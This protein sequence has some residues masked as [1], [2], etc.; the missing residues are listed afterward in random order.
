MKDESVEKQSLPDLLRKQE[1][2]TTV[3]HPV[4]YR[5]N[6][7]AD[8]NKLETL[9]QSSP[10]VTIH[11]ELISQLQELI[12]TKN[13]KVRL[14]TTELDNGVVAHLGMV[15]P[16]EYG[17][18]VYY[19]WSHKLIHLL[20][21]EEF[22]EVRT[23]RNQYK[24]TVAERDQLGKLKIG[25]VGLSV[26][27]TIAIT[28][29]MERGF[30]EI[31]LADFDLLELTNLNRIQAGVYQL[32]LSK[33]I[34]AAREI[35]EIDPFLKCVCFTEGLTEENMARFFQEGGKLN[36]LVEECDGLD[37]KI[38]CR[39]MA[40]ALQI[41]VV[42][43]LND[44]GML[45]VERFDLEPERALLHG[46][47]DH[48]DV[49]RIKDLTNEQ[50]IPYLLPMIGTETISSKLKASMIEVGQSISSWPQLASS[51]VLGGA[52]T[53]DVC[54]R[55][56]L[57]QYHE[58]GRYFVDF[59][60]LVGDKNNASLQN[61]IPADTE[62]ELTELEMQ[63]MIDCS[64]V[65]PD[66][67]QL[68]LT[69]EQI[70]DLVSAAIAAPSG[71]NAQPWKWFVSGNN[72][73]LFHDRIRSVSLLD[74]ADTASHIGLG[75]ATENLILKAH[76]M[77]LE[78]FLKHFLPGKDKLVAMFRFYSKDKTPQDLPVEPHAVDDLASVI[79]LRST[80]RKIGTRKPIDEQ[81]LKE[82]RDA[83]RTIPGAGL[84]FLQKPDDLE[85]CGEIIASV[86]R[87]RLL[88]TVGH[89]NFVNEI[90]WTREEAERT[91]D[92]VDLETVDLTPSEHIGFLMARHNDVIKHL[93]NWKGGRAFENLA[94][95]S[96][97]AA[98]CL[99]LVTMPSYGPE[100]FFQGGRAV[101]RAW[102][103]ANKR[104]ISF[105]P[106]SPCTFFFSRLIQ[107]KGAGL[108]PETQ[109]EL[110]K[111]RTSFETLFP[112]PPPVGEIFLFRLSLADQMEIK[113]LRRLLEDVLV[114]K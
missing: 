74:Y 67:N 87:I 6:N 105:Q 11:D 59:E 51:V 83:V 9:L 86:E 79:F 102:L 56:A 94:R 107:G 50:K 57:D 17:V 13:P 53:A 113:S 39:Q 64:G 19:P 98:S 21:E 34:S 60:D 24:I 26:G 103:T 62:R 58:S 36:I 89:T 110:K 66:K 77:N 84:H 48:L 71:G 3:Y 100:F 35:A 41:P 93:N 23:N 38:R 29:A 54:R 47:I 55:I 92:G 80:N 111:L 69:Q 49:S 68:A 88:H 114:I 33:A 10:S 106:V 95:K 90:R 4:F 27:R 43:Q 42:M 104:R 52:L 45:D 63:E 73:F 20:D 44:R 78:V 37:I 12:K 76:S 81:I 97:A 18:W 109:M 7:L 46:L 28:L 31:R 5:L 72:L 8:K 61:H 85:R 32:G 14:S 16:E 22:I 91:R 25:V 15:P 112:L 70:I 108:N 40:K 1:K 2:G 101:Q 99:G 82:I 65:Q 30:G 75:A 96:V